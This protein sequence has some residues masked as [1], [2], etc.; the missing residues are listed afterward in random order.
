MI[1]NANPCDCIS[2]RIVESRKEANGL[3]FRIRECLKCGARFDTIET[4]ELD[5]HEEIEYRA[6]KKKYSALRKALKECMKSL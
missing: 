3:P 1:T 2:T 4:R 5:G 6:L